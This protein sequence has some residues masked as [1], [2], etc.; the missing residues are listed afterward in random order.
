MTGLEGF[1]TL[2]EA[3]T[4]LADRDLLNEKSFAG[5]LTDI[6]TGLYCDPRHW[7]RIHALRIRLGLPVNPLPKTAGT[8]GEAV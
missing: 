5:N 6:L 7:A 1:D 2:E 8:G 3:I 4:M